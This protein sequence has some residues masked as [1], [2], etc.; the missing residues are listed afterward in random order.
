MLKTFEVTYE[1]QHPGDDEF[2]KFR[3]HRYYVSNV[4]TPEEAGERFW[5]DVRTYGGKPMKYATCV[6]DIKEL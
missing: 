6:L 2:N 1:A 5:I 3:S 4:T